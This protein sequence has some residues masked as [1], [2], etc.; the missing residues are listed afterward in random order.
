MVKDSKK[1]HLNA[2]HVSEKAQ[3]YFMFLQSSK[4]VSSIVK[5][6]KSLP[7]WNPYAQVLV[8]L[9]ESIDS[10]SLQQEQ[11][12][13][14]EELLNYTMLNVN[15][16]SQVMHSNVLQ[17][18]TWF[19]YACDNCAGQVKN[20]QMINQCISKVI[21]DN[22]TSEST[23]EIDYK[24]AVRHLKIPQTLNG[25]PLRILSSISEPY[26]HYKNGKFI[27]GIEILLIETITDVLNMTPIFYMRNTTRED[28]MHNNISADY[29]QLVLG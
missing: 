29:M 25:C 12:L 3:N 26:T 1:R 7:T 13:I 10:T 17:V 6:W 27:T 4:D 14:F 5:M 2:S 18:V 22:N 21:V 15:I 16:M 23:I 28:R 20:T 11:Q 9:T 19:P 24:P 8:L